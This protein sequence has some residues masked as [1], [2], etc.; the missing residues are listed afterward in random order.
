MSGNRPLNTCGA[1]PG[2]W[3]TV[4]AGSGLV[5]LP[6]GNLPRPLDSAALTYLC[7]NEPRLGTH[8]WELEGRWF[9][10]RTPPA[11]SAGDV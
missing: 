6:G 7:L 1:L 8:M 5:L 11:P 10:P 4:L 9:A 3:G 2:G